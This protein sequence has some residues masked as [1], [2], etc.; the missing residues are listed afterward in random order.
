MGVDVVACHH[1]NDFELLRLNTGLKWC[2]SARVNQHSSSIFIHRRVNLRNELTHP[3]IN[4]IC[5]SS[6][7][8]IILDM[9]NQANQ[10]NKTHTHTDT[11]VHR[12][13]SLPFK[14]SARERHLKLRP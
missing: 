12:F 11:Y 1:N 4:S 5:N 14:I 13:K 8:Y 2:G 10:T 6:L 7:I 9:K 3:S